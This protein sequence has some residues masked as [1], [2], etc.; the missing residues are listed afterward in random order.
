M[1]FIFRMAQP[2][3]CPDAERIL[4]AALSEV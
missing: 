2:A 4:R 1:D 3:D